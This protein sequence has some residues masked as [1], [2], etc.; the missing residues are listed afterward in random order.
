M[1]LVE[2]T[3]LITVLGQSTIKMVTVGFEIH[4]LFFNLFV[5]TPWFVDVVETSEVKGIDLCTNMSTS[6][7][8]FD[9]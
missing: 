2:Y 7:F 1:D 6:I 9:L 3:F 5:R 4:N 8:P